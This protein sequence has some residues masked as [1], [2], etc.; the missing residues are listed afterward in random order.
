MNPIDAERQAVLATDYAR[1]GYALLPR[2]IDPAAAER[3]ESEHRSLP[4]RSVDVGREHHVRWIE[5][6]I[7]DPAQ[8]LASLTFADGLIELVAKIAGLDGVDVRRTE[9]WINRYRPGESVPQHCDGDGCTQLVLCLQGVL[10]PDKGGD[11]IIRDEVVPLRAGDGVL[12]LPAGY[13]TASNRLVVTS[14]VHPATRASRM[15]SA[16]THLSRESSHDD[17]REM[18]RIRDE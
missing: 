17:S 12:F 1:K 3:W 15:C 16:S 2:L 6:K 18:S 9:A 14:S 11:L 5:Q 7:R 13:P 4:G 8:A 10:E